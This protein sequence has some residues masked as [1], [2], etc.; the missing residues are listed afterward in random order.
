M[1]S[2]SQA[3][4]SDMPAVS[5]LRQQKIQEHSP[6]F[7]LLNMHKDD[8]N[9]VDWSKVN[10][11][12]IATG[13]NDNKVCV[14]DIRKLSN[15]SLDISSL[16][17][18]DFG[19]SPIVKTFIGHTEPIL[20]VRFCPFNE[21]FLLSSAESVK[22][23]DLEAEDPEEKLFFDHIGHINKI[24]DVQWSEDSPWSILS[25]SDDMDPTHAGCS[26]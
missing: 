6:I 4:D 25:V 22:I 8:I 5:S 7:K 2:S 23:W 3:K 14:I 13:S 9:T 11:N 26:L 20:S 17:A 18:A 10:T 1:A 16:S 19:R 24:T 12:L 15:D 21:R